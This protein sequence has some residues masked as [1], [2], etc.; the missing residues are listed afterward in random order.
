MVGIG[1]FAVV[2]KGEWRK[3]PQNKTVAVK[4][5]LDTD[6]KAER[7]FTTEVEILS[8]SISEICI[9]FYQD[10]LRISENYKK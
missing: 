3:G 10:V 5:F 2:F 6:E 1:A 7:Q 8:R 9:Q 4:K